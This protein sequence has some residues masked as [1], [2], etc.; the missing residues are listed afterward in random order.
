MCSSGKCLAR[1]LAASHL[2]CISHSPL[3]VAYSTLYHSAIL[4]QNVNND[5]THART[6]AQCKH[7]H[8]A[9]CMPSNDT[10]P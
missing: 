5:G 7:T 1:L 9:D 6:H 3:I 8:I 10:R 4:E 2:L